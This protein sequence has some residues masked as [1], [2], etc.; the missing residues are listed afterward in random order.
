MGRRGGG[1]RGVFPLN[2][3]QANAK[4]TTRGPP[5]TY[6]LRR[7]FLLLICLFLALCGCWGA[8]PTGDDPRAPAAADA[9]DEDGPVW[10]EDVTDQLGLDFV[11]EPG[12][13]GS[14]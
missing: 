4:M 12:P 8:S 5:M 13:T 10:F 6:P 3:A 9:A 7:G 2:L 1:T 11:H 14:Y